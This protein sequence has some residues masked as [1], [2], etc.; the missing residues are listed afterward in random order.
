MASCTASQYSLGSRKCQDFIAVQCRHCK[1]VQGSETRKPLTNISSTFFQQ[2]SPDDDI[3]PPAK[4][5]PTNIPVKFDPPIKCQH[6]NP[7]P[8]MTRIHHQNHQKYG[9]M[10]SLTPII[11]PT[12]YDFVGSN[13]ATDK[14][15]ICMGY[16][17][18]GG[19]NFVFVATPIG[20]QIEFPVQKY[21]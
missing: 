5:G 11:Y 18:G 13:Q 15:T 16:W 20:Q 12:G 21:R 14:Y 6:R 4:K 2:G 3:L 19:A 9:M 10:E 7:S 1:C 8:L 17:P